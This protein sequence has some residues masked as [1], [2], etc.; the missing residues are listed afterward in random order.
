MK[1]GIK[2]LWSSCR[3]RWGVCLLI[4]FIIAS[5]AYQASDGILL[6]YNRERSASYILQ[7]PGE[8]AYRLQI[9]YSEEIPFL[10]SN[11]GIIEARVWE[12]SVQPA[13][14]PLPLCRAREPLTVT[15][16]LK[17]GSGEDSITLVLL[18]ESG[19]RLVFA[20]EERERVV[21]GLLRLVPAPQAEAQPVRLNVYRRP[22][23][24]VRRP[25]TVCVYALTK[26]RELFQVYP[27]PEVE[28]RYRNNEG[29]AEILFSMQGRFSACLQK[30]C[31]IVLGS[32]TLSVVSLVGLGLTI[33]QL[34]EKRRQE[35]RGRVSALFRDSAWE[36]ISWQELLELWRD[37]EGE[38]SL[39]ERMREW[40]RPRGTWPPWRYEMREWLAQHL[41][42][43]KEGGVKD[44][45]T[46]KEMGLLSQGE[47]VLNRAFQGNP[48]CVEQLVRLLN[49]TGLKS[50]D[51]ILAQ[52]RE[53]TGNDEKAKKETA[54]EL[55]R[56][57]AAGRYLVFRWSV[58]DKVVRKWLADEGL[59]KQASQLL[60]SP[61]L[62]SPWLGGEVKLSAPQR[63]ALQQW[64][65]RKQIEEI[66]DRHTPFGPIHAE[67]DPRLA[68][69]SDASLFWADHKAW[70][71]MREPQHNLFI[72][73]P[74]NGLTAFLLRAR[75]ECRPYGLHPAFSL[76]ITI[77]AQDELTPAFEKQWM[78]KLQEATEHALLCA[79]GIDPFWLLAA[80]QEEQREIA[81]FL[82][83]INHN[84]IAALEIKLRRRRVGGQEEQKQAEAVEHLLLD[85]IASLSEARKVARPLTLTEQQERL[86]SVMKH[87]RK[88]LEREYRPF[89]N[90]VEHDDQ[91]SLPVYLWIE[92]G[93]S[94][95]AQEIAQRIWRDQWL[96]SLG[97]LKIFMTVQDGQ[98]IDWADD[99]S[100]TIVWDQEQ[101]KELLYWRAQQAL[102][103]GSQYEKL[104]QT[105]WEE[106]GGK[107]YNPAELI[108]H[109]NQWLTRLGAKQPEHDEER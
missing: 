97:Y 43:H 61:E 14:E 102:P 96:R 3:S 68:L 58:D 13:G 51:F 70:P 54:S 75:D 74:G 34:R 52:L 28:P 108:R 45:K 95:K 98:E 17:Q 69:S 19:D 44:L 1:Q 104:A 94:N 36:G 81:A 83:A 5:V 47:E 48:L 67:D 29:K 40:M 12:S 6:G 88:A 103:K 15:L 64:R 89:L 7:Y 65:S 20:K 87:T 80:S 63:K 66:E 33:W 4:V 39:R 107:I 9:H 23:A 55:W 91:A 41:N 59:A 93:T 24:E 60:L 77:D 78:M 42:Q 2:S 72:F 100:V 46:V 10:S 18:E 21:P 73:A 85:L 31:Q 101:L 38:P 56:Y 22:G 105:Y 8:P 109:G 57:G 106:V 11:H 53:R 99:G 50:V 92:V 84:D 30:C 27:D 71:F 76:A 16:G 35:R 37:I 86:L 32:F 26:D 49:I 62:C 25:V 79:M 90:V 82:Y